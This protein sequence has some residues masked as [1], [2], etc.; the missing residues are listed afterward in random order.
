[1]N[2][3]YKVIADCR[4][5]FEKMCYGLTTDKN[6]VDD[7]VQELMIYMLQM[8]PEVL[9][10]IYT[11]DGKEGLIKYGAV[12][13][14]RSLTS[15]R[16]AYYYKYDKY[17]THIDELTSTLTYEYKNTSAKDLYNLPNEVLDVCKYEQ[18]ESIDNALD[19]L[20]WYDSN[21]FKLYYYKGKTLSGLAEET[22]ISRNSLFTTIDKVREIL[23]KKLNE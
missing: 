5:E 8:N 18:L 10:K 15:V 6:T 4:S 12:A 9:S 14:R 23:K 20:Y 2:E 1:M 3:I 19:G 7:A 13:L 22:G 17:Y 11:K 21:I 16:S